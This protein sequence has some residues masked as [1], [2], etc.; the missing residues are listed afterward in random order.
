MKWRATMELRKRP[1]PPSVT[2][3]GPAIRPAA[4]LLAWLDRE[5]RSDSGERRR[6]RLPVV[7]RHDVRGVTAAFV[8]VTDDP[9]ADTLSLAL[10]D[11]AMGVSLADTL[12]SRGAGTHIVWLEGYWGALLAPAPGPDARG[13]WPFAVLRVHDAI[14]PGSRIA[15]ATRALVEV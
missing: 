13:R 10:D 7:V 14:T 6:F 8:G 1:H 3:E 2:A 9:D 4:P 5:A 15:D 12:R 11:S